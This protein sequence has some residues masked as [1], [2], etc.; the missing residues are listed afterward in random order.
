M[1]TETSGTL[2]CVAT[3]IGNLG[4]LTE[5]AKETLAQADLVL[6][7]DTRVAMR[8]MTHLGLQKQL[9]SLHDHNES[10]RVPL[11]LDV[12]AQGQTIAL[13]SDAGTPLISDPGYKLVKEV[14]QAG[15]QVTPIPGVSAIITA[16]SAAGL[17][18]DRFSFEGFLPAKRVGREKHLS[19]LLKDER[20]LVF[21]ESCHRIEA[22]LTDMVNVLGAERPAVIARELTKMYETFYRGTL[23]ELLMLVQQDDNMK[24]GEL[25]V[26]V[27]GVKAGEDEQNSIDS[28]QLL[29]ILLDELPVK[30]AAK[31]AARIT[32]KAKNDL[33][34]RAMALQDSAS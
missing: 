33:Y 3:P 17:P 2:Y 13:I 12:L 31:L 25:V 28:D 29:T 27:Q 21:Y 26:M 5:R 15:F 4:D 19:T 30:Q 7:E 8:L 9:K 10:Q 34:R 1:S 23:E 20:T 11:I 14:T 24:R 18:T 6:A 16:L 32:G 22:T